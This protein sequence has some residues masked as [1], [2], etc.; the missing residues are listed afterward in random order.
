M[1]L[2]GDTIKLHVEFRTFAG[3][4]AD[5]TAIT[6]NIYDSSRKLVT[7]PIAITSDYKVD[8]GTYEYPYVMPEGYSSLYYE[9]IGDPES[10]PAV[11]RGMIA[12]SW[13]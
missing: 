9:F 13:A 3:V 12:V 6:L 1:P 5:P 4:L 10:L 8:V 2:I 7:G 11:H